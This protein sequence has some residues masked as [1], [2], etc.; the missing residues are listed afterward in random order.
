MQTLPRAPLNAQ[1]RVYCTYQFLGFHVHC[2]AIDIMLCHL[3]HNYHAHHC[4][5]DM[6][7]YL[8]RHIFVQ[9]HYLDLIPHSFLY[10]AVPRY[11]MSELL[12]DQH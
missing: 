11:E 2:R 9:R 10:L 1:G 8:R 12:V 5:I 3:C 7:I 6:V 4:V